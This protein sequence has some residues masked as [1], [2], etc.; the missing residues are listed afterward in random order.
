MMIA[1]DVVLQLLELMNCGAA[2][3]DGVGSVVGVNACAQRILS[4]D[5]ASAVPL[6]AGGKGGAQMLRKLFGEGILGSS[7][8]IMVANESHSIAERP[9]IAQKVIL[10]QDTHHG[11]GSARG[12]RRE[13]S[14]AG[15]NIRRSCADAPVFLRSHKCCSAALTRRWRP[16]AR[17]APQNR[18]RQDRCTTR[19]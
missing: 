12:R 14:R 11:T 4:K 1:P 7:A 16:L 6:S 9:L 3:L 19:S 8:R 2:L 18:D 17:G 13:E 10:G 5:G 15:P